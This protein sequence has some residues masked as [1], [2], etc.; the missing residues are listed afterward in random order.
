MERE[1]WMDGKVVVVVYA[2]RRYMLGIDRFLD[3]I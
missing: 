2:S 1:G 3:M